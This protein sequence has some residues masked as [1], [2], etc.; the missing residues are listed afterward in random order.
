MSESSSSFATSDE[1]VDWLKWQASMS[2]AGDDKFANRLLSIAER[3]SARSEIAP[4]PEHLQDAVRVKRETF[5][6]I[7]PDNPMKMIDVVYAVTAACIEREANALQR[8]LGLERESH[9]ITKRMLE[10]SIESAPRSARGMI[11]VPEQRLRDLLDSAERGLK[12][13]VAAEIRG[14]LLG[15]PASEPPS[16]MEKP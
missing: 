10:S 1:D 7:S 9:D 2:M 14:I 4:K 11:S 3:L 5:R 15:S 8:D 13:L 6:V 12:N 16:A